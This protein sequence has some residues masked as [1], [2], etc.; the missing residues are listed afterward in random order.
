MKKRLIIFLA[1]TF[2]LTYAAIFSLMLSGYG[3]GS[4]ITQIVFSVCMLLPAI[5]SI[6]TRLITKQGFS[7]MYVRPRLKGNIKYYLA[8]IFGPS[9]LIFIG[10]AVFF[11]IFPAKFDASMSQIMNLMKMQ[12]V[13]ETAARI[14]LAV[15]MLVGV[16]LGGFIN[17]PFAWGEELGWRGYLFPGLCE[18][19]CPRKAILLTGVIWGL[20][21]AP[22]IAMGH[23]Y[24][25]N[26]PGA[27]WGGILAMIVFCSFCGSFFSYLTYRT[28][29][30]LPAGIAHGAMNAMA[31]APVYFV[32]GGY[33]RFVGPLPTGIIGGI[34]F[35][36]MGIFCFIK[37]TDKKPAV[38][39]AAV[40]NP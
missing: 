14:S 8:A 3:L 27:P 13:D 25:T 2:T 36:G 4:G 7:N 30:S 40:D 39:P 28:G 18:L 17:L 23:N 29:S 37:I 31:A 20:W 11:L 19:T 35:I 1:L 34:G 16:V 26:Y 38:A 22:M 33:S 15:Q 5:C 21:H 10:A 6:L 12:G 32:L 9:V 24:G